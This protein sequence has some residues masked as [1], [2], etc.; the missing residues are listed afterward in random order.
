MCA[1]VVQFCSTAHALLTSRRIGC[2]VQTDT[3]LMELANDIT[4][5]LQ[6]ARDAV[7]DAPRSSDHPGS[8]HHPPSQRHLLAPAVE[9]TSV[10]LLLTK[11]RAMLLT[12]RRFIHV[13]VHE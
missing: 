4:G 8:S 9:L 10:S 13:R 3:L 7:P 11:L 5:K 2:A 6:S 12:A 1:V